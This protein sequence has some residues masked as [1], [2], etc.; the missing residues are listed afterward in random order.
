[1]TQIAA[2]EA[3][4][5]STLTSNSTGALATV[6]GG[7]ALS[8][9]V[10]VSSTTDVIVELFVYFSVGSGLGIGAGMNMT[11]ATTRSLSGPT[12]N[13]DVAY[14]SST[15]GIFFVRSYVTLNAGTTNFVLAATGVG[16]GNK[17]IGPARC[18]VLA[19]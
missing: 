14:I 8:V 16:G 1:M 15:S 9:P 11:G 3:S 19:A 7:A 17:I 10:T 5:Q 12:G 18:V 4:G 6:T 13:L 2:G